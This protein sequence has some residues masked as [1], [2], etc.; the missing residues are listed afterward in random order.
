MKIKIIKV[1]LARKVKRIT[2]AIILII[3]INPITTATAI[4]SQAVI[5]AIMTIAPTILIIHT[6]ITII[7]IIIIITQPIIPISIVEIT[8][9]IHTK[10]IVPR[11][12][13]NISINKNKH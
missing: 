7:T 4:T 3:A 1:V 12:K 5:T 9:I 2:T 8:T 10:G 13:I 6:I 11:I